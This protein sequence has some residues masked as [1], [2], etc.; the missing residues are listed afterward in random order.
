MSD[1]GYFGIG[2]ENAKS[3]DN[4]GTLWRTA[5]SFEAAYVYTIGRRY[6]RQRTDTTNAI[7]HLPMQTFADFPSFFNALPMGCRLVGI[8]LDPRAVTLRKYSHHDQACY[9]LGAEDHGL[10]KVA[11]DACHDLI[12][13]PGKHCLNVAVAGS[14]VLAHRVMQR[15]REISLQSRANPRILAQM[16]GVA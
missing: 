15:E 3:S 6:Q 5:Q 16:R 12:V 14:I 4:V 2:I 11:R 13:L 8:E 10:S 1:R 9:L 7:K